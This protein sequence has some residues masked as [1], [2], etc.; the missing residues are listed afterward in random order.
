MRVE[1]NSAFCFILQLEQVNTSSNVIVLNI[2]NDFKLY[3]NPKMQFM[4]ENFRYSE[5]FK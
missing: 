2:C 3:F 1:A 4:P 5:I